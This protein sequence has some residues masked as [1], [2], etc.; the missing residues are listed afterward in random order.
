MV[1]QH[2]EEVSSEE[3]WKKEGRFY[4]NLSREYDWDYY[5]LFKNM[6]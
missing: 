6:M 5:C 3:K 2:C 4:I 1:K